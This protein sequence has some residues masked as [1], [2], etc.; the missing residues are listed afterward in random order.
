MKDQCDFVLLLSQ[1]QVFRYCLDYRPTFCMVLPWSAI[2][3]VWGRVV[4]RPKTFRGRVSKTLRP[5]PSPLCAVSLPCFLR[6]STAQS[7]ILKLK[8]PL[9]IPAQ[10]RA[11]PEAS[12]P[13]GPECGSN[14]KLRH[15]ARKHKIPPGAQHRAVLPRKPKGAVNTILIVASCVKFRFR[16]KYVKPQKKC[17]TI[18]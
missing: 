4:C 1:G 14:P 9:Q 2:R 7:R 10:S 8:P 15:T 3:G 18:N 17:R 5:E 16:N 11:K 6:K 13:R 12:T